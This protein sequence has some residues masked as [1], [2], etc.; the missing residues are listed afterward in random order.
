MQLR[1]AVCPVMTCGHTWSGQRGEL[2][3]VVLVVPRGHYCPP[4]RHYIAAAAEY[5]LSANCCPPI[6]IS[7]P[8]LTIIEK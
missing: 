7:D 1:A 4:Q 6:V 2:L 3:N 5:H 8:H